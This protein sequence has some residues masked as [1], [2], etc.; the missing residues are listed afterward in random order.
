MLPGKVLL[1]D[2]DDEDKFIIMD[3]M[4]TLG[5]T[6]NMWYAK[7]GDH[8]L[9]ML[10]V[11]LLDNLKP[12]LI[13]LDLNMPKMNGTET[14]IRLKEDE[15]FKDIPVVIY[16]TSINRLEKEKCMKLGAHSYITKPVSF[17]ESMNTARFFLDFCQ[18]VKCPD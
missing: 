11:K 6:G 14:L 13:V 7:N 12:C 1:V 15:R 18:P 10:E 5:S 17:T 9:E 4:D 2:D 3:A 8:A 16:S